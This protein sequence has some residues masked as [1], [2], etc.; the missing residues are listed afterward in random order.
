MRETGV[1]NVFYVKKA[2]EKACV[3][4]IQ[5]AELAEM[6]Y[7]KYGRTLQIKTEIIQFTIHTEIYTFIDQFR[8]DNER[9]TQF[10]LQKNIPLD[11]MIVAISHNAFAANNHFKILEQIEQLLQETKNNL[12]IIL[13]LG[14]GRNED[15]INK[16]EGFKSSSTIKIIFLH[17][18]F[19]PEE[20]AL[21]RLSTDVMIQMPV[22]DALSAAMTEV[23]YAGKQVFAGSW[24]PYGLLRRNGVHYTEIE[25]YDQ[26][27]N[28]LENY[29]KNVIVLK[30]LNK[31]NA[32]RISSFLFPDK[33]TTAW[34][35]IFENLI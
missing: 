23:L 29:I 12:A 6:M 18:F 8:N 5:N 28:A 17:Q 1:R 4:S 16:L 3:I 27:P 13:P 21:L 34:N 25:N 19:D 22:S 11:K 15:Y 7:C 26:L 35:T 2:L 14:Y 9:I 30:K 31:K 24:L 20:I 10:K 33:T 32:K